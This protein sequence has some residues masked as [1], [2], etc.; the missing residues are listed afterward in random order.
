[1]RRE[2]LKRG[3]PVYVS[4]AGHVVRKATYVGRSWRGMARLGVCLVL[5]EVDGELLP[6]DYHRS[7]IFRDEADARNYRSPA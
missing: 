6:F 7:R 3:Q 1:M 5:I 2:P 4:L